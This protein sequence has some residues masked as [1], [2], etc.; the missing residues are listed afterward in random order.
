[1]MQSHLKWIVSGIALLV[2]GWTFIFFM[3][4]NIFQK[5][6][7][8]SVLGYSFSFGGLMAGLYGVVEYGK[9]KKRK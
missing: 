2:L 5:S 8:L 7:I 6:F 4:I 3:V 1:M 9:F